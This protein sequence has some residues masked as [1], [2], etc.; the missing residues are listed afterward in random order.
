MKNKRGST[1]AA[2]NGA[3]KRFQ[4]LKSQVAGGRCGMSVEG[5]AAQIL[6]LPIMLAPLE[7]LPDLMCAFCRGGKFEKFLPPSQFQAVH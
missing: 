2:V 3:M 5:T 1:E 4:L 7:K 6:S